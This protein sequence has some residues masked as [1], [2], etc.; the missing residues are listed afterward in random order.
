MALQLQLPL[1]STPSRAEQRPRVRSTFLR[2]L[3]NPLLWAWNPALRE[4]LDEYRQAWPQVT[5]RTIDALHN[6]GWLAGGVEQAT[7]AM[8]GPFM[9]L[10]PKPDVSV[11]GGNDAA[12][13][14]WSRGV[15]RRFEAWARDPYACDLAGRQNLGQMCAHAVKSSYF[16]WGEVTGLVRYRKRPGNS[17]GTKIQA[18]PPNRIPQSARTI[19]STQGMIL[20]RDGLAT[21]Y[22]INSCNP[23][24][25]GDVRE[26]V[27]R[28]RDRYGRLV[29]IHVHDG[30]PTVLRGLSPL[31][32]ALQIVRQYDQL[33]NATLT[34]ALIQAIFAATIQGDA[35][36]DQL[37]TMLQNEDEQ[38]TTQAAATRTTETGP[39]DQLMGARK[40]WYDATRIDLGQHGKILHMFPGETLAFQRSEHP[41]DN[42]KP[43]SRLLLLEI[44]KCL[45]ITYEQLTGDREGATYSSERTGGAEIHQVILYR[46]E[47]IPARFMQCCY[48]AWLEEDIELGHTQV[49][50]GIMA[51]LV[52]RHAF[53][54]ASW[55]GPAR[56]AA[57]ELKAAKANE[58]KLRNRIIT[59]QMWCADE[60]VDREDADDEIKREQDNAERL[61]INTQP[62][63][64][65]GGNGGSGGYE[66]DARADLT[67][68]NAKL[69][70]IMDHLEMEA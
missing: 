9:S 4:P 30:P 31:A 44:A 3:E 57:D 64:A 26:D 7:A 47:H 54:R 29:V 37:L 45:G 6:S 40:A 53:C 15:K 22:C 43:Y 42:F 65:G 48:E 58:I 67:A 60:D 50:G 59:R 1:D 38:R 69:D 12:A 62:V 36:S 10:T 49:P 11:F 18:L 21:H 32:P 52:N 68:I 34:A 8:C 13:T 70:D 55:R 33:A 35:P 61:G 56:P 39:F 27:V 17:H 66:P 63:P 51:F 46:R 5:A 41:N 16:V 28:A 14:E 19:P 2:G 24:N 20:D 25:P 23:A